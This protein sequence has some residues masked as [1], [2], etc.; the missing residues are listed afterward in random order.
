MN[1]AHRR[2]QSPKAGAIEHGL[3]LLKQ[4]PP[5]PALKH[6]PFTGSVR[7]TQFQSHQETIKLGFRQGKRA[8]WMLRVL[9]R[10]NNK[11]IGQGVRDPNDRDMVLLHRFKQ[12]ALRLRRRS[13]H[14]VNQHHL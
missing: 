10:Q 14:L 12:R 8:N 2:A 7:H 11:M 3:E 4:F 13:V 6:L 5:V 1:F 9:C